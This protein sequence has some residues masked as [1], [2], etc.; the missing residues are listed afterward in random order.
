MISLQKAKLKPFHITQI[1]PQGW[2]KRQLE[3]QMN[4]LTGRLYDVWDSV[5]SYSGW[6]GGTGENWERAPYYL[7]GLLPLSF[8][9]HDEKRCQLALRF[10]EWTLGSQDE[11]G[12]FGPEASKHDY[13]S[14]FV[15]LKVLIQYHEIHTDSRV[16][17]FFGR[18]Y[19][20]LYH[21]M[22]EFPA[23]QWARARI[24]D[25]LYSIHWYYD[26]TKDESVFSLVEMLRRQALDWVDQFEHFAYVRPT[27]YYYNWKKELSHFSKD[28]LDGTMNYHTNH[29]VNLTMGFKYP[30]MLS[31]FFND[32]DFEKVSVQG[33]ENAV[34]YHGVVSGAINGD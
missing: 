4:G 33:L 17:S 9:L 25:L 27:A 20:Y 6:L 22:Q 1:A 10:V 21:D 29:I 7:D 24:G 2:L 3:I 34:R 12:N 32:K 28:Q 23:A 8:Y 30:A 16:L 13:W 19:D 31:Y 15:M 5:G 18:Y 14:R 26:L 11:D